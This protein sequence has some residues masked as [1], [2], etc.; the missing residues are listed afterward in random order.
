MGKSYHR[1]KRIFHFYHQYF[2]RIIKYTNNSFSKRIALSFDDGPRPIFTLNILELLR[3]Y[4]ISANFFLIG[5]A[6][7][8]YPE[9]VKK[10]HDYNHLI[11][12]HS[13]SHTVYSSLNRDDLAKELKKTDDLIINNTSQKKV[14]FYRPP[15]GSML[16]QDFLSWIDSNRK[17]IVLWSVDSIDYIENIDPKEISDDLISTI[18]NGDIILFHDHGENAL[19]I[20]ELLLPQLVKKK[21]HFSLLNEII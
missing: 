20:L 10:I 9:I 6:I 1:I 3:K 11:G 7:E 5:K 14:L 2:T 21:Y 13:Y 15:Y 4:N 8:Q 19:H 16:S 17:Y 18:K 12:N